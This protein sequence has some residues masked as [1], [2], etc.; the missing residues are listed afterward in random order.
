MIPKRTEF[1]SHNL[2]SQ[3]PERMQSSNYQKRLQVE[4]KR[5]WIQFVFLYLMNNTSIR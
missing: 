2:Y 1:L 4:G 3:N 5:S